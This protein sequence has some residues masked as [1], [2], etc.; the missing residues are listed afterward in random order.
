[1]ANQV[2]TPSGTLT[3]IAKIFK[4]HFEKPF[5]RTLDRDN[6]LVNLFGRKNGV[7]H[8]VQWIVH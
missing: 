4:E 2:Y 3:N 8:E 1:M 6:F 5:I 7:G